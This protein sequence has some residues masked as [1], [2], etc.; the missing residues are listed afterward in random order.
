MAQMKGI[1]NK[2][3]SLRKLTWK[4]P[5]VDTLPLQFSI[6]D[7]ILKEFVL[8]HGPSAVLVEL[9]QN[10]Y[11]AEGT[12]LEMLFGQ[13]SVV[14]TGNGKPIDRAGWKRLSVV[15]GTGNVPGAGR[16]VKAKVNSIGSKN[17]GL[18]SLFNYGDQIRIRSGG[19]QTVLDLRRGTLEKPLPERGSRHRPGI[20][21]EVPYRT[22]KKDDWQ[23]FTVEKEN[24]VLDRFSEDLPPILVK[25]ANPDSSKNLQELAVYSQ[26]CQRRITWKQSVAWIPS[27]NKTIRV[28]RRTISMNDSNH[29]QAPLKRVKKLE[30]IEFQKTFLIPSEYREQNIPSYFRIAGGRL[31]LTL[32]IRMK[33]GK[34]DLSKPG[35]Y[36]YPLGLLQEYTGTC[37]NVNAPFQLND[38]RTRIIDPANSQW[39]TWLLE[40]MA[41]F[42]F[43]LL[44]SDWLDRFGPQAYIA[45]TEV[46]HPTAP[47]FLE[48]IQSRLETEECWPTRD[49]SR[50]HIEFVQAKDI[51]IPEDEDID[52]FLGEKWYLD[53][54]L[55]I[56]PAIEDMALK[57][58]A[59]KFTTNSLVRLRCFGS[60]TET[61]KTDLGSE[62]ARHCYVE[63]PDNLS[64]EGIQVKYALAL[65]SHRRKLSRENRDDLR[66]SATTLATDNSLQ[67][68]SSHLWVVDEAILKVCRIPMYQ[69]L[70]P[71]LAKTKVIP[72]LCT[73]FDGSMWARETAHRIESGK[74]TDPE[75]EALY[76]YILSIHGYLGRNTQTLLR[77]LPVIL[78]HRREWVA[79]NQIMA[80]K[81]TAAK[82]L[83]AVMHFT[84]RDYEG[85]RELAQALRFKRQVEVDDIL[86]YAQLVE[87]N[88]KLAEEFEETLQRLSNLLT[89]SLVKKLYN[90]NFLQ[91]SV[92]GLSAPS[93]IY[94]RNRLNLTCLGDESTF[95]RGNRTTLYTRLGCRQIPRANDIVRHLSKLT[96]KPEQLEVIYAAL[97]SA[98]STE[99]LPLDYYSEEPIIWN[100]ECYN[101]PENTIIGAQ[102]R[103]IFL[104]AVP[105]ISI[106]SNKLRD[107][108]CS[109][110]VS[111]QPQEKHWQQLL[112]WFGNRYESSGGPVPENERRALRRAYRELG[113]IPV[114]F[115]DDNR[116][117][118]DIQGMLH[119][120]LTV[121]EERFLIDDNPQLTEAAVK[122]GIP[123]AFADTQE[124]GALRFFRNSGVKSL[125]Q[126]Q[127]RQGVN[128]GSPVESPKW[129]NTS[130]ILEQLHL[131]DFASALIALREYELTGSLDSAAINISRV[132]KQ[133]KAIQRI[134]F[135]EEI[136]SIY[137]VGKYTISTEESAFLSDDSIILLRVRSR[138][139]LLGLLSH[140]ISTLLVDEIGF[141]R[142]FADAIYR[143]LTCGSVKEMKSYLNG[144]GIP[145]QPSSAAP[146][147][148][149]IVEEGEGE[150]GLGEDEINNLLADIFIKT[151][152]KGKGGIESE[153]A[154][155]TSPEETIEKE[156]SV[157]VPKRSQLPP[158]ESLDVIT[159]ETSEHWVP[160][161]PQG[162]GS[163][164]PSYWIPRDHTSEEWE[165]KIGRRGEEIIYR[166]ELSRVKEMGYSESK[167]V[168]VANDN[169]TSDFDILSVDDDGED[170]WI[171][172][173]STT[174]RDG[175]FRWPKA[176]FEKAIEKRNRYILWRVYE[177]DTLKPKRKAFRDPVGILLHKGMR[178]DIDNFF[179]MVEP[180]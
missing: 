124:Y 75:R 126:L 135:T 99:G 69:Q 102:Y 98:L 97:A 150:Y 112:L 172:V 27:S 174:G 1:R 161:V 35:L 16:E 119:D 142:N 49:R 103:K 22:K 129:C 6:A 101:S 100:G 104:D 39:N 66:N 170:I 117:F 154:Q 127:R 90:V 52:S 180:M 178:L 41:D 176:E 177:A 13:D 62:E 50:R 118:L 111:L 28:L 91:N 73:K 86:K 11:D 156:P 68:P 128:V 94:V 134:S 15:L 96:E 19:Q 80:R 77:R 123:L 4:Q 60:A 107:I 24:H 113:S 37:I 88:L 171:E 57:Y 46:T 33:R 121:R 114:D 76:R 17:F 70:H 47:L 143:L 139:E 25:L 21:I 120:I 82:R 67:A 165:K 108:L 168:W 162:G 138:S 44:K 173:K 136:T 55:A 151:V 92:G 145:W 64:N 106:K 141:Q 137:K 95:V 71:S 29:A 147:D 167:V 152:E 146:E 166:Q 125:T 31:R 3:R 8:G 130:K 56:F 110:G 81:T 59:K 132:E 23:A 51:R 144:R 115:P 169:P 160:P 163:G 7:S 54:R 42:I 116:C 61:M 30:E 131:P 38:D 158:I 93:D 89:R 85:D 133:L 72:A 45:L 12:R 10:E 148:L 53:N 179:A 122:Q 43:E 87:V 36:Y 48:S 65:D 14:I 40:K 164:G 58:G 157:S 20:H 159:L 26:R 84:N 83:E 153:P 109:L 63:F 34:V 74:V 175:R 5:D 140:V 79:P 78:D 105:C 18:R 32:S 155:D 2:D 9:V 149:E